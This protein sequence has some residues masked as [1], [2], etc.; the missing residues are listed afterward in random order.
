MGAEVKEFQWVFY[1]KLAV[2]FVQ[3]KRHTVVVLQ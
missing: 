1:K 2:T 3:Q